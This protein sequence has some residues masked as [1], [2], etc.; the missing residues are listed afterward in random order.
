MNQRKQITKRHLGDKR[1]ESNFWHLSSEAERHTKAQS[2][3]C[4]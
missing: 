4:R 2:S 1:K 3:V